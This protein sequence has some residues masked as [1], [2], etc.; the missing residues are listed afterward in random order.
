MFLIF[1]YIT[2]RMK[3]VLSIQMRPSFV[4]KKKEHV[5]VSRIGDLVIYFRRG[6]MIFITREIKYY[7]IQ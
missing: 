6:M 5:G 7:K 1:V 3:V 2:W 4:Q